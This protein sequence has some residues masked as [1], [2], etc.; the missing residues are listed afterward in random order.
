LTL[1]IWG[2]AADQAPLE[3]AVNGDH[4]LSCLSISIMRGHLDV[5]KSV[6]EILR[7]QYKPEE[8][9]GETRFEIGSDDMS[10][11]DENLNIVGETIDDVFT[12][13]NVGEVDTQ[14]ES[15]V[16]PLRALQCNFK[17]SLFLGPSAFKEA[18][19]TIPSGNLS[20][21]SGQP[22]STDNITGLVRYAVYKND[23]SLLDFIL[24]M[25]ADVTRED[26]SEINVQ[27]TRVRDFQLAI[28]LG[29]VDCLTKLIQHSATGLPLAKLSA[30]SGVEAP[31]EPRYYQ[32][33]SIRG[34]KR[35]DWANAGRNETTS[36]SP[37]KGTPLLISALQGNLAS[38]EFF[39]GTAPGRYYLE[40]VN[41][42]PE[43]KDIKRIAKSKLGLEASVL[44]WLQTRSK[45]LVYAHLD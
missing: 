41:S 31:K 14:V 23:L 15:K 43:N 2:P 22:I 27:Y 21:Y 30:D 42:H 45:F 44:N 10:D 9:R 3:I 13:D 7:Q 26:P 16:S 28:S 4:G 39:L 36:S 11:D 8:A 38:T 24:E 32:G 6:L 1:G 17:A 18:T 33:L 20:C 12:H 25:E 40:Y 29:R 5:A 34:A 35:S 19:K 37:D